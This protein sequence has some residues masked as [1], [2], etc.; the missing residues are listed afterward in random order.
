MK[1]LV[2]IFFAFF[3][4]F[5]VLFSEEVTQPQALFA[6]GLR[7]RDLVVLSPSQEL[8]QTI[9]R[10]TYKVKVEH[11]D[12]SF[13]LSFGFNIHGDHA[14]F[15]RNNDLQ[16][17]SLNFIIDRYFIQMSGGSLFT[18]V[19]DSNQKKTF[20]I[21]GHLGEVIVNGR[22]LPHGMIVVLAFSSFNELFVSSKKESER[23]V[24]SEREESPVQEA[25]VIQPDLSISTT[26]S[27][28]KL[29]IESDSIEEIKMEVPPPEEIKEVAIE[30]KERA[31]FQISW[32]QGFDFEQIQYRVLSRLQV[33]LERA[34]KIA[35]NPEGI[36]ADAFD[37][38]MG[39][40]IW[41]PL[42]GD[43]QY[44]TEGDFLFAKESLENENQLIYHRVFQLRKSILDLI[45]SH[46]D[47]SPSLIPMIPKSDL[48]ISKKAANAFNSA[49]YKEA[50]SL[51]QAL[52]KK[53]KESLYLLS[54][55]GSVEYLCGNSEASISYLERAIA[56]APYDGYSYGT[57]AIV[58]S[59]N[60]RSEEAIDE[61]IASVALSPEIA[62]SY[63]GLGIILYDRGW[64][65]ESK[66]SLQE[67]LTRN[68]NSGDIHRA[69]AKTMK[70]LG[71]GNGEKCKFHY[72]RSLE[73]GVKKDPTFD[74]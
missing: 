62:E 59:Q 2:R 8:R 21:T 70:S 72:K 42:E 58:K 22:T 31:P 17:R 36:A 47:P 34:L 1:Y 40:K 7:Q 45:Q 18:I 6:I 55:L 41:K 69:L 32:I 9:P 52:H 4:L 12:Y 74:E 19:F 61:A 66:K 15:I 49:H 67:G 73:L 64:Y 14:I 33:G 35:R 26:E 71:D 63:L 11:S 23:A 37:K 51:Y 29:G 65:E 28:S 68:P 20:G 48:L 54:N 30:V 46:S 25:V 53:E 10:S 16:K 57:L 13:L 50:Q 56:L 39:D 44:K 43:Q 60:G 24:V 5:S 27:V 38:V 3:C